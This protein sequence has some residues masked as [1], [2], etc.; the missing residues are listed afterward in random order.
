MSRRSWSMMANEPC[1]LHSC[2]CKSF[3]KICLLLNK[4]SPCFLFAFLTQAQINNE[5]AILFLKTLFSIFFQGKC[6][7]SLDGC[8]VGLDFR[9]RSSGS[10]V[11]RCSRALDWSCHF[12]LLIA[13]GSKLCKFFHSKMSFI[14]F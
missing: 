6:P 9:H 14:Y 1:K 11:A 10:L 4:N 5:A 3:S 7:I 12:R 13:T 2:S 8:N